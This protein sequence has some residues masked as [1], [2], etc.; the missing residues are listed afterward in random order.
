VTGG[1]LPTGAYLPINWIEEPGDTFTRFLAGRL[2]VIVPAG[3]S[4][5]P[6]DGMLWYCGETGEYP[7]EPGWPRIH[8]PMSGTHVRDNLQAFSEPTADNLAYVATQALDDLQDLIDEI[9]HDPWPGDV[10]PSRAHAQVR[11]ESLHLWYGA[12]KPPHDVV[13]TCEP[14]PLSALRCP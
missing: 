3:F 4:V 14:I 12:T 11:G 9:T 8:T 10:A 2:S 5:R 6:E 7:G 13:L 1:V